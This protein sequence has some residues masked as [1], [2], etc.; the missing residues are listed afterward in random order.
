MPLGGA[1][2][3]LA[4]YNTYTLPGY[5]QEESFDSIQNVQAHYSTYADGSLSEYTGLQNKQLS[6]RLK[7]WEQDYIT[8][9]N[10]IELAATYLR[11]N[12]SS[13]A[14]L[15]VQYSDRH[16]DALVQSVKMQKA[17]GTAVRT[18]EYEVQFEC[19]PWLI[20]DTQFTLSGTGTIN[21]DQVS[22]TIDNGGYTPT[23]ITVTGTDVTIS[24]YTNTVPFTGFISISGAISGMVIDSENM[25]AEIS[26]Q[27]RNDLM[28]YID[29][30]MEVGP[31]KTYFAITGALSCTI[32][33]N[34]RWYI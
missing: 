27:N 29:Y 33:Y 19:R 21:T 11:T 23:Y 24:G 13:F 10:Q 3:Y 26:G 9:K 8:T 25:T 1:Q 20:N 17:V 34:D 31:S 22:R 2:Q 18:S 28:K 16:Y 4:K 5:V 32:A 15:Y 14:P 12:K 6:L 7:V 30:K